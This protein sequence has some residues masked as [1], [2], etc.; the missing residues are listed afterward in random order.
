[1]YYALFSRS[2]TLLGLAAACLALPAQA[3]DNPR[4]ITYVGQ[5]LPA[6]PAP[7]A[8]VTNA[9]GTMLITPLRAQAN[10]GLLFHSTVTFGT[11]NSNMSGQ[12]TRFD[13]TPA[14]NAIPYRMSV[15]DQRASSHIY[16][17]AD[18]MNTAT[19]AIETCDL[20]NN[21]TLFP[22][23]NHPLGSGAYVYYPIVEDG[24]G[25]W[26]LIRTPG[27]W[28]QNQQSNGLFIDLPPTV[29]A[30]YFYSVN[31]A[32]SGDFTAGSVMVADAPRISKQFASSNV[33][34]GQSTTLTIDVRG[35]GFGGGNGGTA[36]PVPGLQL[37]D[38]LPA[39]LTVTSAST[40][41]QGGTLT[42]TAGSN[43][44]SL[45]NA[46]LPN[47]GCTVTVDVLWPD[48]PQGIAA[49][50]STPRVVNTITPGTGFSTAVGQMADVASAE[51]NCS[52]SG[53]AAGVEAKPVPALGLVGLLMT[54]FGLAGLG[55]WR[56]R[57]A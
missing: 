4:R 26:I 18:C 9:D 25:G 19:Q 39:P 51:L 21:T 49:C 52:Y 53:P 45:A 57:R 47:D 55:L 46:T 27:N 32:N 44:V 31:N 33:Q 11:V 30:V 10:L 16:L 12:G 24:G 35:P 50:Q 37:T 22:R 40:T 13:I 36:G 23:T 15:H 41:C 42:A 34:P 1:M 28:N 6:A 17:Y 54:S 48:T 56:R 2:C 7:S 3:I 43:S 8:T 5:P 38:L 29:R 14:A 20:L